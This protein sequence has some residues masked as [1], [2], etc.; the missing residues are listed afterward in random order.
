MAGAWLAHALF[1]KVASSWQMPT[2]RNR[3]GGRFVLRLHN[4]TPEDF[5]ALSLVQG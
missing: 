2:F 3:S 4:K 5:R 1:R